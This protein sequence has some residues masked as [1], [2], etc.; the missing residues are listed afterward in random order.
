MYIPHSFAL[1]CLRWIGI[2]SILMGSLAGHAQV[3][4]AGIDYIYVGRAP[5][6]LQSIP[7]AEVNR[8]FFRKK[9]MYRLSFDEAKNACLMGPPSHPLYM[10]P[11]FVGACLQAFQK[12]QLRAF[13][14]ADPRIPL[15]YPDLIED[16]LYL[17]GTPLTPEQEYVDVQSLMWEGLTFFVDLIADEGFRQT[18]SRD[19][20]RPQFIRLTWYIPESPKGIHGLLLFRFAEVKSLLETFICEDQYNLMEWLQFQRFEGKKI[21]LDNDPTGIL[22]RRR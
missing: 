5:R 4:T 12:R 16:M 22:L 18:D 14:P 13:A 20:F 7:Q 21:P 11:G 1:I 6:D 9:V 10:P 17:Q 19:F 3:D 15:T 8:D 2:C